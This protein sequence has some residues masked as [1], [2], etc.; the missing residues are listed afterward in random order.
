MPM[1]KLA[2]DAERAK[3]DYR[4]GVLRDTMSR[5]TGARPGAKK[6]PIETQ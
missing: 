1:L 2:F 4:N 3:A 6:A 5:K